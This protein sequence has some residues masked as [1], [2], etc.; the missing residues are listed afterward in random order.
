MC[1]VI[2]MCHGLCKHIVYCDTVV[3]YL[4]SNLVARGQEISLLHTSV[5]VNTCIQVV[6]L[7]LPSMVWLLHILLFM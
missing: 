2:F 3:K 5:Y 4:D 6:P 1:S 7:L